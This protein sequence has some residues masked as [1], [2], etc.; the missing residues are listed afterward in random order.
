[1]KRNILIVGSEETTRRALQRL[2]EQASFTVYAVSSAEQGLAQLER[3]YSPVLICGF[4]IPPLNGLDFIRQVKRSHPDI[5]CMVVSRYAD[6]YLLGDALSSSMVHRFIPN[7]WVGQHLLSEVRQAFLI[8]DTRQQAKIRSALLKDETRALVEL[9]EEQR[10]TRANAAAY[11]VLGESLPKDTDETFWRRWQQP[12]SCDWRQLS[13][14]TDSVRLDGE[15]A[16]FS[17]NLVH[18]DHSHGILHLVPLSSTQQEACL[19]FPD[20]QLIEV[21]DFNELVSHQNGSTVLSMRIRH[22]ND[23]KTA[24][25]LEDFDRLQQAI[26]HRL[27]KVVSELSDARILAQV[28]ET[29]FLL[30]LSGQPDAQAV[31]NRVATL[32]KPFL[33]TLDVADHS[34]HIRFQV[35]YCQGPLDGTDKQTLLRRAD[36]AARYGKQSAHRICRRFEPQLEDARLRQFH[37][38]NALFKAIDEQA[39]TLMFQPKVSQPEGRIHS[40]EVLLRW[41]HATIGTISPAVFIPIAERD[42]QIGDIGRWVMEQSCRYLS[43]W[44]TRGGPVTELAVNL[45]SLQLLEKDF[46]ED[47]QDMLV[48][49]SVEPGSLVLELTESVLVEDLD[50]SRQILQALRDLGVQIAIDDFGTGYSSLNYLARLPIDIVK[51]DKSLLQGLET[52]KQAQAMMRNLLAMAHE[53]G[54]KVVAEGVETKMELALLQSMGCDE[55]QGYIY[56]RPLPEKEFL[57]LARKNHLEQRATL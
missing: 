51:L 33:S 40:A 34:F 27:A 49:H 1:M 5:L 2:L 50:N 15:L 54:M 44:L 24:M 8:H 26:R 10:L 30:V 52:S 41:Q 23:M 31:D 47:L 14:N 25:L 45:S 7:P 55:V 4:K 11:R 37:I 16:A 13:I 43:S 46:I 36:L 35:G 21:S 9:D 29:T 20:L 48:S 19:V 39:L 12:I 17:A 42:G 28:D 32:I 38:S 53:L 6:F 22:L 3:H 18:K 57:R 56:S